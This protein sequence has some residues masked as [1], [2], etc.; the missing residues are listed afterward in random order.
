V[1]QPN[2]LKKIPRGQEN[3]ADGSGTKFVPAKEPVPGAAV[4]VFVVPRPCWHSIMKFL[5]ISGF[6]R[7]LVVASFPLLLSSCVT[8]LTPGAGAPMQMLQTVSDAARLHQAEAPLPVRF[9]VVRLQAPDYRSFG[10]AG[11]TAGNYSVVVT[12]EVETNADFDAMGQWPQVLGVEAISRLLLPVSMQSFG[13]LRAAAASADTDVLFAYTFDT[14]FHVENRSYQPEE[15]I[16]L[17]VLP[18]REAAVSSTAAGA[19]IDVR[20]GY[21]YGTAEGSAVSRSSMTKWTKPAAADQTRLDAEKK[22]FE[23]MMDDARHTWAALVAHAG[24]STAAKDDSGNAPETQD[25]TTPTVD[26]ASLAGNP[27]T[28]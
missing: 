9:A 21:V 28:P 24:Q 16:T 13:D 3:K 2:R 11:V 25:K 8:Y 1:P 22:A 5:R 17:G 15:L 23:A 27:G 6:K 14:Q 4:I 20:S 7:W 12:R 18:G 26:R 19:F 10:A